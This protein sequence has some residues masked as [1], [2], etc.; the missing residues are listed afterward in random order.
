MERLAARH[1]EIGVAL[2]L[3]YLGYVYLERWSGVPV[4]TNQPKKV[5]IHPDFYVYLPKSYVSS[6]ESAR[7]LVGKPLWRMSRIPLK[8]AALQ[9]L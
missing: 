6:L 3:I 8:R 1:R 7:K 9:N 2:A 4:Q 5:T